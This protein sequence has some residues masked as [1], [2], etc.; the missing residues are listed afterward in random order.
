[1]KCVFDYF[2]VFVSNNSH[3]KEIWAR[4]HYKSIDVFIYSTNY[5]CQS[6][7]K[8]EFSRKILIKIRPVVTKLFHL[9][10][11]DSRF[12]QSNDSA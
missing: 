10:E 9:D 5:S 4:Y 11:A 3:S 1:M 7:I 6:S 2:T 12:S 8:L